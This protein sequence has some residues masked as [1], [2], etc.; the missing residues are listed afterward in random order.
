MR[1]LASVLAF[2]MSSI[3]VAAELQPGQVWAYHARPGEAG[4]TITV[5]KVENYNDLG[6]VVHI[7]VDGVQI[8]NPV[9]G[10]VVTDIPHLPFKEAAIQKSITKLVRQA[11]ALPQFQDGYDTWKQAYLAGRAGAFDITVSATLDALLGA[12]WEERK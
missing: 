4:S 10:N 12:N 8:K 7:R 3:V 2:A 11:S 6:R 1:F 5:L 9:K